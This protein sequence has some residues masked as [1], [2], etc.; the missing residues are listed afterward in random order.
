[1]AS[2]VFERVTVPAVDFFK[3]FIQ[4][5]PFKAVLPHM[6]QVEP[7]SQ[8]EEGAVLRCNMA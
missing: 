1:M 8:F 2:A 5:V 4:F 7:L 3:I 6:R